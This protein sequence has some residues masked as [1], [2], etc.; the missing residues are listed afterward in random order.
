TELR[1]RVQ[2]QA[3]DARFYANAFG[4]FAGQMTVQV[5]TDRIRDDVKLRRDQMDQ[6]DKEMTNGNQPVNDIIR[7]LSEFN[8][9][10]RAVDDDRRRE[11]EQRKK[12]LQFK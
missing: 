11:R 3:E 9:L 10:Q 8:E 1:G 4:Q 7:A 6:V 5:Q 2:S 12:P